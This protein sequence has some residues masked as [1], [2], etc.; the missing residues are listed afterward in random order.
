MQ[1]IA[2]SNG[3]EINYETF[4]DPADPTLLLVMGLGASLLAWDDGICA[5]LVGQRFHVVR[6]DNRDIGHSTWIDT[7]DLD[8]GAAVFAA[9]G[10][11]TSKA[12]YRLSD[13]AD[14]TVGLLDHLGV[15]RAHV[16]GA[17]M[18]GMISQTIAI[19]HRDRIRSLTSIMSTTGEP[20]VGGASPEL[21]GTLLGERPTERDAAIEFG[22]HVSRAIASPDH[23][24]EDLTRARVTREVDH[25][26]NP[27]GTGRQLL[28]I[29]A[30]GSRAE[31]LGNLDLPTLVI[32]GRHDHLVDFSGG[33]RTVELVAGSEFL[34]IDD[35]G[36]D[37]PVVHYNRVVD[38][39]AALARRAD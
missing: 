38:E 35:M 34:A 23:F 20:N 19:E 30:S 7:P 8:V 31:G 27:L 26:I 33:E 2:P 21:L 14:D 29:L 39:I 4:G 11:D 16:V 32:H 22:V 28:A 1:Q 10:G 5:L 17:S 25:G 9:I 6:F 15:E 3:I 13:M 37:L 12:P 36:H 24:D 18:G